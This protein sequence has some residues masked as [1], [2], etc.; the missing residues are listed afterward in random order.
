MKERHTKILTV[1]AK[2]QK[3]EVATLSEI[4]KVS[5]VT[6][7]KDLDFLE[8]KGMIRR[9]HGYACLDI[10]NDVR[11]R[12]VFHYGVKK[13]IA[14]AAA[15]TVRDGE[16]VMIESGSCCALLAE[17][18]AST[19]KDITIITN[20]AFIANYIRQ[21]PHAKII[22]LGGYFQADSQ[23]TVGPMTKKCGEI[24]FADKYFI[25]VDGFSPKF[26]FTGKDHLRVQTVMDLA[27]FSRGIIVLTES[28][29]FWH[30]GVLRLAQMDRVVDVYTDDGIPPDCESV[31][32][33]NGVNLHKVEKNDD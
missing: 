5:Q 2:N 26:G 30:Q 4:L 17:E 23:V 9:E 20:S 31:L 33:E 24:F 7:R 16:T 15:A 8:D 29:K 27:E 12:M 10:N 25:G 21:A 19:K 14:K 3:I 13:R 28:E 32:L 11:K 1:L 18:L 22:L 6:V